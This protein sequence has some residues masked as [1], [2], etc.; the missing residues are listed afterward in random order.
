MISFSTSLFLLILLFNQPNSIPSL[1]ACLIRISKEENGIVGEKEKRGHHAL[2]LLSLPQSSFMR[3]KND[4]EASQKRP[5]IE[6]RERALL[7]A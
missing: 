4:D 7:N 5:G 1:F 3:G 6:E 2:P